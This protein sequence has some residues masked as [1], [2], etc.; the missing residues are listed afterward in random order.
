MPDDDVKDDVALTNI[1]HIV[2]QL[3][4][5]QDDS[6]NHE[7]INEVF[8]KMKKKGSKYNFIVKAGDNFMNCIGHLYTKIW[9]C[10]EKP[11]QWRD[12]K[13]IQ[14][15]K[16]KGL[17]EDLDNIRNI[18]T[19]NEVSK[20]FDQLVVNKS[21]VKMIQKCS[22]FQIGAIQ[23]H[24]PQE[25]IFTLKSMMSYYEMLKK[26]L[27]VQ[28]Y[29]LSKY[30]DKESL[31]DAMNSLHEA[32]IRGK[33]YRLWYMMNYDNR[34]KVL[35]SAGMSDMSSTG[36]NVGQGTVGGAILSSL[37]LDIGVTE[38]FSESCHEVYYGGSLRLNP[39]LYQDDSLRLATSAKGAQFGNMIM[40]SVMKRKLLNINDKSAYLLCGKPDRIKSIQDA[41]KQNPLSIKGEP[42]KEKVKEKYLGEMISSYGVSH[43][44]KTTIDDRKGRIIASIFELSSIIISACKQPVV[45]C[46][47]STFG[48]SVFFHH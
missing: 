40:E 25:H 37:N 21:K 24:R 27:I 19:K 17:K 14:L 3:C 13:I 41:L 7:D 22:K 20:G 26:P 39:L 48:C 23:G 34:V 8:E 31:R 1:I 18:H 29:D 33:L 10:E 38:G 12:T 47:G 45:W 32:N 2:R 28:V 44:V 16:S 6:I 42:I 5:G 11:D 46:L 43:S 15:Y 9:A 36:E 30:F 4:G 35:T